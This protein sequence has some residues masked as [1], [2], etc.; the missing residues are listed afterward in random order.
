MTQKTAKVSIICIVAIFIVSCCGIVMAHRANDRFKKSDWMKNRQQHTSQMFNRGEELR[1]GPMMRGPWGARENNRS[2]L[3]K[4]EICKTC[5]ICNGVNTGR[6]EFFGER[7]E[8]PRPP[9]FKK[10]EPVKPEEQ[11]V[12]ESKK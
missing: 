4:A 3:T 1:K 2:N 5:P 7:R 8:G 9:D 12:E 6:P 10:P 11:K